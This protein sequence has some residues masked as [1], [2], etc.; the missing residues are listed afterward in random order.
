[1]QAGCEEEAI[2]SVRSAVILHLIVAAYRV[3]MNDVLN[4]MW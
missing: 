3:G 2:V 1:M 4:A